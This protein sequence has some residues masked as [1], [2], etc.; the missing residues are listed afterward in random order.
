LR[1][2]LY[3]CDHLEIPLPPGH[4]F[5]M[6]K[7][8]LLRERLAAT[9]RFDFAPAPGVDPTVVA[10]VHDPAY[11]EAFLTGSLSPAAIRRIGFPWS[12]GLVRR[13]MGSVGGTLAAA[14]RAM[15]HGWSGGLAGGTHHA[16]PAEGSGFCIFNDIYVAIQTLRREGRI[17]RALVVDL[18][19]HQ[20]D[21]TALMAA[22]DPDTYTFSAHGA[23]NFPFRKQVSKL[24]LEFADG[25]GDGEYLDRVG[26]ALEEVFRFGPDMVF[27]QA[28][29]DPLASDTLGRLS[30]T[31]EGLMERDRLVFGH[32]RRRG[33]P[34]VV[35]LGGGYANPIEDTVEAHANTF[36]L[37]RQSEG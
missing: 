11:V 36:L 33:L 14:R 31:H 3:Y 4:R 15:D 19:V 35:T 20:G 1:P 2:L 6:R 23:G 7:Y 24:D 21:G 25:T 17:Q 26:A 22:G 34:F 8:R 12:E 27:Y 37:A 16:F 13:T 28:G 32:C 5:P 29:V 9:D 10:A 18:D 30:L